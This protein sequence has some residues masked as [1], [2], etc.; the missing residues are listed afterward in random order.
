MYI[1]PMGGEELQAIVSKIA[2]P[3]ERILTSLR[4]ATKFKD[5]QNPGP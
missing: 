1:N 3:P 5:V 2:G 4:Q